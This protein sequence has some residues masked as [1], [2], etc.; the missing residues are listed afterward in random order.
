MD[1]H[2]QVGNQFV[3][4]YYTVQHASPKHLHRFYSDASTLTYGDVRP[5]GCVT[6]TA[7]GQKVRSGRLWGMAWLGVCRQRFGHGWC[8]PAFLACPA[9]PP[10]CLLACRHS[11]DSLPLSCLTDHP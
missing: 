5:E 2:P 1:P 11:P 6:R 8:C 10:R 4:Q 9:A 3:S 7:T